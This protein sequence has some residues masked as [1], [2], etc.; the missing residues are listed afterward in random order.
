MQVRY[1]DGFGAVTALDVAQLRVP[2]GALLAVTGPSG[3]GKSTLLYAVAGLLRP[4]RGT[5]HWD[6]TDILA[7]SETAGIVGWGGKPRSAYWQPAE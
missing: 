1:S 3:S 5:V 4:Q 7:T 6:G 2:A